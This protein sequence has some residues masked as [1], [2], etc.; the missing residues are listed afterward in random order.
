M[1]RIACALGSIFAV[2]AF[3]GGAR[4]DEERPIQVGAVLGY[5]FPA[6]SLERGSRTSD[7]TFSAPFIAVDGAYR[8]SR[9]WS[10]GA[11][12]SYGVAIPKLCVSSSDCTS[13]LGHDETLALLGRWHVG[14]WGPFA[15]TVDAQLGY[16]WLGTSL[17]DNGAKSARSYR[18][19]AGAL[20]ADAMFNLSSRIALGL[21]MELRTGVFHRAAIVAS[22]VD[23]SGPTDGS[24][25]HLWPALGARAVATF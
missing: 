15:P 9:A 23:A 4:A 7:V 5:A 12:F 20:A 22:G 13:S 16:E 14:Q 19:F 18:G 25:L 24:A 21:R 1:T 3:A 17:S 10:V 6:G 11:A 8:V 2:V